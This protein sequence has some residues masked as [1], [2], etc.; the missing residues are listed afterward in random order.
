MALCADTVAAGRREF[1]GIHDR[2][3]GNVS[4]ARAVAAF[5]G[6]TAF[7]KGWVAEAILRA[8]HRLEEA[9]VARQAGGHHGPRQERVRVG[10]VRG[11]ES[12]GLTGR[13]P[14]Y[15]RLKEPAV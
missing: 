10:L 1:G 11:R 9:T 5:A 7:A 13:I 6:H 4:I 2:A 14:G 3:A 15:R 12:P 8:F